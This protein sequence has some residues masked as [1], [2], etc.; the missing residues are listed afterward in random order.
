MFAEST[1]S[2]LNHAPLERVYWNGKRCNRFFHSSSEEVGGGGK[3]KVNLPSR[4]NIFNI[5]VSVR[6]ENKL[7]ADVGGGGGGAGQGGTIE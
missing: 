2:G 1:N 5:L 3:L 4:W 7:A 6:L